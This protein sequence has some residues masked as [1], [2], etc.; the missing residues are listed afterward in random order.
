MHTQ[1]T[2]GYAGVTAAMQLDGVLYGYLACV[3][4]DLMWQTQFTL[5][6]RRNEKTEILLE[7][8]NKSNATGRMWQ[9]C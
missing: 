9:S 5:E 3:Y 8:G 2:D 1:G 6:R 7:I 4:S